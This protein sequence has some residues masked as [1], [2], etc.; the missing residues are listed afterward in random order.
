MNESLDR[1]ITTGSLLRF[2]MPTIISNV[3]MGLYSTVDGVFVSR[4]V[5][6]DALSAV[7][8]M[9][10]VILFSNAAGAML[11]AGGNAI[12]ARKLGEGKEQ[13]AREDLTFLSLIM[14]LSS[15]V[16]VVLGLIFIRPLIYF[17]GADEALYPYCYA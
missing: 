13:E 6:T 10:P 4:L 8:I 5:G 1:K 17:L 15:I 12:I 7:N 16:L 11:G 14:V 3:F 2:A 9:I